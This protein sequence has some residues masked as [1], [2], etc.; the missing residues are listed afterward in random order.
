MNTFNIFSCIKF[1]YCV[2]LVLFFNGKSYS[3]PIM[4]NAVISSIVDTRSSTHKFCPGG[5]VRIFILIYD[6]SERQNIAADSAPLS[7]HDNHANHLGTYLSQFLS[8]I[9]NTFFRLSNHQSK[10]FLSVKL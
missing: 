10:P 5:I 9:E 6:C 1:F 4:I 7:F 8:N 3:Q 2:H